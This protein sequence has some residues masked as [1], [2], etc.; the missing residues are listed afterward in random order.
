MDVYGKNPKNQTGE[1]FRAN[2]WYWHPLWGYFEDLHPT[3]ANKVQDAHSNSGDG[4]NARDALALSKLLKK[5]IEEGIT[6]DYIKKYQEE[7][8]AL[9]LQDCEFCDENG[10][11]HWNQ[12]DGQ[13]Q[14]KVC[15]ACKGEKKVKHFATWYHMDIDL[16]KE[17]QQFLENCGGF[18]IC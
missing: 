18:S 12:E 4:L 15:N 3:I 9:P 7:L 10:N 14:V 6:E 1:Y 8:E 2:V 13:V 17:F 5:D 16:M 11:R